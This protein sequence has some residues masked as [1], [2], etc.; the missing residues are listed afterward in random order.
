MFGKWTGRTSMSQ[1]YEFFYNTR[2]SREV[3]IDEP[4]YIYKLFVYI[5]RVLVPVNS[6]S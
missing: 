2:G 6:T 5:N 4:A 3:I 1:L